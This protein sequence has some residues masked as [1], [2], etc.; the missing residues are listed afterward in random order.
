MGTNK[1]RKRSPALSEE[2]REGQLVSLAMDLAEKQLLEGTAS[3][4]VIAHYLKLGSSREQLEQERL[5]SENEMLQAKVEALASQARVEELYAEA[6]S[7]MRLYS[8]QQS[9][10]EPDE[11]DDEYDEYEDVH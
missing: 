10:D 5:R 8:G 6:L 7:A 11:Y 4:Q 1:R 3:S 9:T 2:G